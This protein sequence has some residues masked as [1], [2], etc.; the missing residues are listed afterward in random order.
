MTCPRCETE[1][2]TL[3]RL[4][5]HLDDEWQ[6]R[7]KKDHACEECAGPTPAH[8]PLPRDPEETR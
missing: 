3:M 1:L 4:Y 6:R 2:A 7:F 5:R 8:P